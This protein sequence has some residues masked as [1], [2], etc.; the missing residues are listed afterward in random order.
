MDTRSVSQSERD[1]YEYAI[2]TRC[3]KRKV[4]RI[5]KPG[6]FHLSKIVRNYFIEA[7]S[8]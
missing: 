4:V 8:R 7:F 2:G 5:K 1:K 3:S 6:S